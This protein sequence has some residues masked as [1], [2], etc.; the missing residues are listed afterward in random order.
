MFE[1]FRFSTKED[2]MTDNTHNPAAPAIP[3]ATRWLALGAVAGAALF[4]LAWFVLGFLSP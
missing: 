2:P 3:G 1:G 4:T